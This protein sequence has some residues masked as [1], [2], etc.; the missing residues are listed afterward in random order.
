MGKF[1]LDP[2]PLPS[3]PIG[4]DRVCAL[5]DKVV[6][7][8][9]TNATNAD[10]ERIARQGGC[11]KTLRDR[12]RRWLFATWL[13]TAGTTAE[14]SPLRLDIVDAETGDPVPAAVLHPEGSEIH[15]ETGSPFKGERLVDG[16]EG[17]LFIPNRP[18]KL[19]VSAPGYVSQQITIVFERKGPTRV[20][21]PMQRIERT[22][23]PGPL[24]DM[25]RIRIDIIDLNTGD[26]VSTAVVRV[27]EPSKRAHVDEEG[28]WEGDRI[29]DSEGSLLFV[30]KEPIQIEIDAP[31]YVGQ[32][33]TYIPRRHRERYML[34]FLEPMV[35][36]LSEEPDEGI[37][38]Y[39][40]DKPID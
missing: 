20:R 6:H 16:K 21:V 34:V 26:P 1:R 13:L 9:T 35:V 5:C 4:E 2:C 27:G 7:D 32:Q 19:E 8:L 40:R 18:L 30:D 39:G 10:A 3:P 12:A 38:F 31:G 15:V 37:Y 36:D 29:T 28:H 14:A 25:G 22:P 11:A 33:H 17:V 23:E 24:E